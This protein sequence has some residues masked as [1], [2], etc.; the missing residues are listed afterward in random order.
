MWSPAVAMSVICPMRTGFV[1]SFA[2]SPLYHRQCDGLYRGRQGRIEPELAA[3]INAVA[4][5]VLAE[6]AK[7]L[8]ALLVH[9][10]TDYVLTD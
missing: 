8:G 5:G 10:S 6:E 3:G 4:P 7:R 2:R 1:P 9:Y